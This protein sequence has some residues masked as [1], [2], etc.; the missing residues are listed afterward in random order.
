VS[1]QILTLL[2]QAV[3]LEPALVFT[4]AFCAARGANGCEDALLGVA[5]LKGTLLNQGAACART[6][7][8]DASSADMW[9]LDL[10]PGTPPKAFLQRLCVGSM[11]EELGSQEHRTQHSNATLES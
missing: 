2:L 11:T 6:P 1:S 9:Q 5:N 10:T 4:A 8:A 3:S 7:H